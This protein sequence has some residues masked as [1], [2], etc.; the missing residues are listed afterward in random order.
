MISLTNVSKSFE[1]DGGS[2][3]KILEDIDL[4]IKK[5]E[6]VCIVGPSG[7]G[8]TV[9]L[10]LIAGFLNPTSG[11]LLM[12]GKVIGSPNTDRVMVFQDY[13][14][15]PWKTVYGNVVFGLNKLNLGDQQKKSIAMKY[16]DLVGLTEF[17]DWYVH[18]L[19]GGMR[20]RVAIARALA[21]N[22]KVLLMDEPFSA[23]DLAYRK[24]LRQNLEK[25][26]KKS[27]KT[28][29]LVTHNI[30]EAIY[31]ADKIYIMTASPATIKNVYTVDLPRPRNPIHKTFID[32]NNRI[33]DDISNEFD[34]MT[35]SNANDNESIENLLSFKL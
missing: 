20:Q 10:Y 25:I 16:L 3:I 24:H 23:L 4:S 29:V 15:F 31:L 22:P 32:L 13:V 11:E 28:I 30:S 6:F 2:K 33:N 7:C 21:V 14:L 18:K 8:K 5:E 12:E 26:W 19:S 27:K 9:L 34:K 1:I 17:K 35:E